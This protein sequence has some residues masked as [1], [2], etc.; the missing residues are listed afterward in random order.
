M[1]VI[2]NNR[3]SI[4]GGLLFLE[5]RGYQ[6]TVVNRI[7]E[8]IQVMGNF[9]PHTI[10]LSWNLR[11]SD[12]RKA[13]KVFTEKF[14]LICIVFAEDS[15]TRTTASLMSSGIPHSLLS[16]VSGPSIHMRVQALL[17]AKITH[18]RE[19]KK[20]VPNYIRMEALREP[21][22]PDINWSKVPNPDGSGGTVWQGQSDTGSDKT[23]YFKGP[24]APKFDPTK[25]SYYFNDGQ[26]DIGA[27]IM[28]GAGPTDLHEAAQGSISSKGFELEK[29]GLKGSGYDETQEGLKG[30]GFA[31]GTEDTQDQDFAGRTGSRPNS[32]AGE[33]DPG[34]GIELDD[35]DFDWEAAL[36][37]GTNKELD[38]LESS[39]REA[40]AAPE[41]EEPASPA[42]PEPQLPYKPKKAVPHYEEGQLEKKPPGKV[43][44]G[45]E[46][47]LYTALKSTIGKMFLAGAE[48]PAKVELVSY[49]YAAE[50]N[51]PR[52]KGILY[53]AGANDQDKEGFLNEFVR[54][55]L[56]ELVDAGENSVITIL[57]R[58]KINPLPFKSFFHSHGDF[59][60]E[61]PHDKECFAF[62]FFSVTHIPKFEEAADAEV[63]GVALEKEIVGGQELLFDLFIHL[64]RNNKFILYMNKGNVL[65]E[66]SVAKFLSFG[67]KTVHI[68]KYER[69]FFLSYWAR[70]IIQSLR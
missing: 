44:L 47:L 58:F 61:A 60:I 54:H 9:K 6:L 32:A 1:L 15:S 23:Y 19:R 53:I 64:P 56:G 12:V 22:P 2:L 10:L 25:K 59:V 63:L 8:A 35:E 68:H 28:K 66:R 24:S 3:R 67:V 43:K 48:E 69:E 34:A 13:Y 50:V 62:A 26:K 65:T 18:Q 30:T 39:M 42:T 21:P 11:N 5:K 57:P 36:S 38:D 33:V 41:A 4:D 7:T 16:P 29:P 27:V 37:D 17:R 51:S 46:S 31:V 14:R 52:Y 55:L 70:N 20:K 45:T 49:I 40:F